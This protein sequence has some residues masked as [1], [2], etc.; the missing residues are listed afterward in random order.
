[1]RHSA[2]ILDTVLPLRYDLINDLDI[3]LT[4]IEVPPWLGTLG[5]D[6]IE[7]LDVGNT[8][9]K[10]PGI[11]CLG[12]FGGVDGNAILPGG[13][14]TQ[15]AGELR[16]GLGSNLKRLAEDLIGHAGAQVDERLAGGL[17]GLAEEVHRLAD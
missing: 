15:H 13:T 10:Q 9:I 3:A 11:E 4:A 12:A 2:S 5:Q 6:L 1:M 14:A 7:G 8:T 17:T 16:T